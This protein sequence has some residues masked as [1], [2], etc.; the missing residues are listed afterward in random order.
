MLMLIRGF[1]GNAHRN[2][3]IFNYST[4]L[5]FKNWN[6]KTEVILNFCF[7]L[8]MTLH[9]FPSCLLL[10]LSLEILNSLALSKISWKSWGPFILLKPKLNESCRYSSCKLPQLRVGYEPVDGDE[11]GEQ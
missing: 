11:G 6:S 7:Y 4:T 1:R 8:L 5:L 10:R 3:D 9:Y 2:I